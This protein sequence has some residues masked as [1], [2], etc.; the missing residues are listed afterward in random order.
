MSGY[1]TI[2]IPNEFGVLRLTQS[3]FIRAI[4]QQLRIPERLSKWKSPSRHLC[5]TK[6]PRRRSGVPSRPHPSKRRLTDPDALDGR[7][8]GNHKLCAGRCWRRSRGKCSPAASRCPGVLSTEQECEGGLFQCL[9]LSP[10]QRRR[11]SPRRLRHER[12]GLKPG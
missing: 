7:L 1:C 10:K 9:C 2:G 3:Q 6:R 5:N 12:T 8:F 11:H 4:P